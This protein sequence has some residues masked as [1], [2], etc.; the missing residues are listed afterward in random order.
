VEVSF[1]NRKLQKT[2]ESEKELRCAYG[3]DC[4]RKVMARLNDLR[5]AGTLEDMRNLPGRCHELAGSR[6]GQLGIDLARGHRLVITP[7]DGWPTEKESG[8]DLWRM[9]DA[10]QV[11]EIVDYHDG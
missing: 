4:T 11:L 9:V 6:A 8:A 2:C 7:A 1:A 3:A 10:V 5:A